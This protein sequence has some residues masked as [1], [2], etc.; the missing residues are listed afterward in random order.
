[1]R[2]EWNY[3]VDDN[4]ELS[5]RWRAAVKRTHA[6]SKIAR[7]EYVRRTIRLDVL[8]GIL[9]LEHARR[10]TSDIGVKQAV[11]SQ[12][13]GIIVFAGII[14]LSFA[15]DFL[16]IWPNDG[17]N[18]WV[19]GGL[20][21][22]TLVAGNLDRAAF[23]RERLSANRAISAAILEFELVSGARFPYHDLELLDEL[24]TREIARKNNMDELDKRRAALAVNVKESLVE[25]IEVL[26]D[27][28]PI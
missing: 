18:Y 1:M 16:L 24:M 28:E 21:F 3:S 26:D 11:R 17:T 27:K 2:I 14:L 13:T 5:T 22:F 20:L 10:E 23:E 19:W 25:R 15:L 9:E 4:H 7:I 8:L 6:F 12:N